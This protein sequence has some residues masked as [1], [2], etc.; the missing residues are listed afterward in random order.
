[1]ID[2]QSIIILNDLRFHAS[3]TAGE[4]PVAAD[5][6]ASSRTKNR[7]Q[8]TFVN[9]D[10]QALEKGGLLLTKKVLNTLT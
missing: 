10:T 3:P 1:M 2:F 7:R 4:K 9:I 5:D 6:S 8:R